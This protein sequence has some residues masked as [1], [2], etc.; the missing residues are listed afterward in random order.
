MDKNLINEDIKNM[1]YLFGYKPGRVIS[2]QDVDY[3]TDE[4]FDV[5]DTEL[6]EYYHTDII[7]LWWD[8]LSPEEQ[9]NLY[10]KHYSDKDFGALSSSEDERA[11]IFRQENSDNEDEDYDEIGEDIFDGW[12]D[13]KNFPEFDNLEDFG[14]F[15]VE[16]DEFDYLP[17]EDNNHRDE[18]T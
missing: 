7:N 11:N 18:M 4:Y 15:G 6:N 3:T 13:P 10:Q 12:D 8:N 9:Q 1:K 2:E 5:D 16:D 14:D 17:D